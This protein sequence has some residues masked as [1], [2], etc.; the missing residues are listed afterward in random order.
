MG[1]FGKAQPA[2]HDAQTVLLIEDEPALQR[3]FRSLIGSRYIIEYAATLSD[4]LE[5]IRMGGLSA[6]V[7]DL[8][9][10]DSRGVST[11]RA[12]RREAPWLPVVVWTGDAD[13]QVAVDC[14]REGAAEVAIKSSADIPYRLDCGMA[15][16]G[17]VKPSPS[18]TMLMQALEGAGT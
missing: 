16:A 15:R 3:R 2:A 12:V 4:A 8:N 6:V 13:P 1:L 14:I 11:L 10:P 5:R 9:L 7:A 17:R 18:L